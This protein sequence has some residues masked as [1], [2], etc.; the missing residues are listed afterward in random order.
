MKQLKLIIIT[1][2]FCSC[3]KQR[4]GR[5]IVDY[6]NTP[7]GISVQT[8]DSCEYVYCESVHGVSIVHKS[9]C[10]NHKK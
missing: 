10:K 5:T 3:S 2:I 9:N 8:I 4:A 7:R 6:E 1:V